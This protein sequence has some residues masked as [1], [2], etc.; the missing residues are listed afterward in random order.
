[1]NKKMNI[2]NEKFEEFQNFIKNNNINYDELKSY[3]GE[4]S[5]SNKSSQ[6]D[7]QNISLGHNLNINTGIDNNIKDKNIIK[8]PKNK[9]DNNLKVKNKVGMLDFNSKI[10]SYN[11]N[12]EFLKDYDN[13]SESWRKEVDKML[14]RRGNNKII[15]G[16]KKN[17][18]NKKK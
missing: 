5:F 4:D 18:N 10:G 7:L 3:K 2:L 1:M 17:A 13:F 15:P 6:I 16:I 8:L 12:D 11:F 14:Q 9:S